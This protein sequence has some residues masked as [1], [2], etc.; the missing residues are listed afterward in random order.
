M[1]AKRR[2]QLL[3][4]IA[5]ALD[6]VGDRWALLIVRDL[7][8]GPARYHDLETGLGIATNLL[9]TRLTELT[10]A[11][12]IEKSTDQGRAIYQL[13]D[14]G[15][16]TDR[17]L[18]ELSRF[19]ARLDREP[20]PREPGNLR[21]IA[22]PLRLMIEAVTNRPDL[23]ARLLVDDDS[24]TITA[25]ADAVSVDYGETN[26]SPDLIVRT[27]YQA[28]LDAGEGRIP[29]NQFA[30]EHLEV[31]DGANRADTFLNLMAAA[32]TNRQ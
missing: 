24:F 26:T 12:L 4:P 19:G 7:H 25:T 32:M 10:E 30:S 15:R 16:H 9:A 31:I 29:L 20:D 1:T 22:L 18:W 23:V 28:F 17:V 3:C 11:G 21:T 13:T 8:A 6:V 2:Y 14:L 27:D 5:R